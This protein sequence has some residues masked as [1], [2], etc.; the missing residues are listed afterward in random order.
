MTVRPVGMTVLPGP[1]PRISP[2]AIRMM[3]SPRNPP[4]STGIR[5]WRERAEGW[6]EGLGDRVRDLDL[7]GRVRDLHLADRARPALDRA[8]RYA[9]DHAAEGVGAL[10]AVAAVVGAVALA[11]HERDRFR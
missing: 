9:K 7:G 5:A 11:L 2:K 10:A 8:G 3:R 4:T 6:A 1:I